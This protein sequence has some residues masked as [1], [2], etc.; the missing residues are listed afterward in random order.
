MADGESVMGNTSDLWPIP[1]PVPLDVQ[2]RL[3]RC[4]TGPDGQT[5][6]LRAQ[7]QA[8]AEMPGALTDAWRLSRR[9][10]FLQ[11]WCALTQQGPNESEISQFAD[12]EVTEHAKVWGLTRESW[13]ALHGLRSE[14][15]PSVFRGA[16]TS[17]WIARRPV[18]DLNL[19]CQF[20]P[21]VPSEMAVLLDWALRSG[22]TPPE[23]EATGA[24]ATAVW[25]VQQGPLFFGA[26]D[27]HEDVAL[28]DTSTAENQ[29]F[30]QAGP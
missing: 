1:G 20:E 21:E 27:W 2:P 25:L 15:L 6:S 13:I 30:A 23:Y 16:A 7:L 9:H 19:T 5:L 14:E 28:L 12:Q 3:L 8:R 4:V 22:V 29:L 18:Q 10:W 24:T 11:D 17:D 26:A